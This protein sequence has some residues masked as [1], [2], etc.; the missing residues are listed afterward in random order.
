M[1]ETFVADVLGITGAMSVALIGAR[2]HDLIESVRSRAAET[3]VDHIR[4]QLDVVV[5]EAEHVGELAHVVC[6]RRQ[7]EPASAVWVVW[8]VTSPGMREQHVRAAALAAGLESGPVVRVSRVL[9]GCRLTTPRAE[10][11][12]AEGI[13]PQ[14]DMDGSAA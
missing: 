14:Q 3:F 9:N 7:A 5:F 11:A 1:D 2:D 10:R 13:G 12:P 4:P 6:L 8:N